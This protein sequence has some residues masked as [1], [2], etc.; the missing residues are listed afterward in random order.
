MRMNHRFT[1]LICVFLLFLLP[2]LPASAAEAEILTLP[3]DLTVI[4]EEAF[5]RSACTEL[6]LPAGLE[7]IHSRAFAESGLTEVS[8]PASCPAQRTL[9]RMDFRVQAYPWSATRLSNAATIAAS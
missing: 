8:L 5:F 7:E 4:E 9:G 1:L 2:V 3:A 6:R